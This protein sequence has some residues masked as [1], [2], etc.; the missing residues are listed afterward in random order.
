MVVTVLYT[1]HGHSELS[2]SNVKEAQMIL[3]Q[4]HHASAK[5]ESPVAVSNRKPLTYMR[6]VLVPFSRKA[7]VH[8]QRKK[9]L[10]VHC[11]KP[12]FSLSSV[13]LLVL[14]GSHKPVLL[15]VPT[16]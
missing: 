16:S 10:P 7:L 13:L 8:I 5:G 3:P 1:I 2:G 11:R 12:D 9:L 15:I 14:H 4:K 6:A